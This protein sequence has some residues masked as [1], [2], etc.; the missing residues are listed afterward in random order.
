MPTHIVRNGEN[1]TVIANKY[2]YSEWKTIYNHPQNAEFRRKRP[3]PNVIVPGDVIYIPDKGVTSPLHPARIPSDDDFETAEYDLDYRSE[4]GNLSKYLKARYS[5]GIQKDIHLDTITQEKPR[6]WAAKQEALK[7][8]DDY[9]ATFILSVFPV[10]FFI[11]TVATSVTPATEL[12]GVS[13]SP[14]K[15][16][17]RPMPKPIKPRITP[18]NGEVNV[19]GGNETPNMTN[20]NPIKPGSGGPSQGIPNHVKGSMEEMDQIFAP[21]TVKYMMSSRLRFADVNWSQATQ[22]AA[23]V[24][25]PGAKVEMNVWCQAREAAIVKEAFERAGFKSVTVTGDGAGTMIR[26]VW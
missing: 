21:G 14:Y 2:R 7:I 1:L 9:N 10:V 19:G 20:L 13:K 12:P 23:K 17:R 4:N 15:V 16:S 18:V 8:M 26:A 25:R 3:N 24:M 22:A 5:N 11:L 6:L